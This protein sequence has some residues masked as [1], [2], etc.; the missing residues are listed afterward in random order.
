MGT[1]NLSG[2]RYTLT[3]GYPGLID[4]IQ[5]HLDIQDYCKQHVIQPK[6]AYVSY[7]AKQIQQNCTSSNSC[8]A[9]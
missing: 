3:H 2:K 7:K 1:H 8:K 4:P 6:T 5:V 9:V